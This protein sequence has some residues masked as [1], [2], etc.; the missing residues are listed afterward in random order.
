M[1]SHLR[2]FGAVIIITSA[3]VAFVGT[4]IAPTEAATESMNRTISLSATGSV[5]TRPDA[6]DITV[7]VI[8]EAETAR[9]ALDE[10]NVA[11]GKIVAE[12]KQKGIEERDIQTTNFA[13]HPKYQHFQD[14]KP[15]VIAGYR[16]AN[17]VRI[18]VRD[19]SKLGEVLDKVVSLGSNQIGG[20]S[21]TVSEPSELMDE[22]R[23]RAMATARR[24]AELYAKAA[25]ATLGR[26]LKIEE[27]TFQPGPPRP[28]FTAMRAEAKSSEVPIE[29][30][31]AE[32]QV[33]V[34]VVWELTDKAE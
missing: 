30:G 32:V 14:G 25:N 31:E 34:S 16:V 15:S 27:V 8:S 20:V 10:N 23:K 9:G 29:S 7:G 5:K 22:A 17:S 11:M 19:L 1:I 12:L 21:F 33:R 13:V 2:K 24:K 18:T 26:V 3:A 28:M 6:A 4:G